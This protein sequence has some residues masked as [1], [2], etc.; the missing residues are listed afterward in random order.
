MHAP[1]FSNTQNTAYVVQ[2]D[3][4]Y[5]IYHLMHACMHAERERGERTLCACCSCHHPPPTSQAYRRPHLMTAAGF[6]TVH[7]TLSLA[8]HFHLPRVMGDAEKVRLYVCLAV[9]ICMCVCLC[10]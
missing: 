6:L 2:D 5:G 10:V 8:A 1:L 7:E 9:R 4:L 3:V